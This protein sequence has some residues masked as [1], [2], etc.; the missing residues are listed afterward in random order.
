MADLEAKLK[1]AQVG[2]DPG[3]PEKGLYFP[4][5]GNQAWRGS[6]VTWTTSSLMPKTVFCSSVLP[7]IK[8]L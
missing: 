3:A 6:L 5:Q 1:E 4:P 8:H 7:E 2:L